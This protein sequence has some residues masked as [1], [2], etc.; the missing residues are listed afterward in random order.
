MRI[1]GKPSGRRPYKEPMTPFQALKIM[2]NEMRGHFDQQFFEEF[3]R[4]LD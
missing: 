1:T 2:K 4:L 3:V